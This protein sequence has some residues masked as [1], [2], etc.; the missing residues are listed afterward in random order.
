MLSNIVCCCWKKSFPLYDG[1]GFAG[2]TD[3]ALERIGKKR[4]VVMSIT[5]F[6]LLPDIL[7]NS[8]WIAVAPQRWIRKFEQLL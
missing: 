7:K 3:V 6:L 8:D 4:N 1:G 2:A 5:S